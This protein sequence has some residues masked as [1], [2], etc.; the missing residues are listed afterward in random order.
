[1]YTI[2]DFLNVGMTITIY[3]IYVYY[4]SLCG[5]NIFGGQTFFPELYYYCKILFIRNKYYNIMYKGL[6]YY[7]SLLPIY[8]YTAIN[9]RLYFNTL[10]Y[11]FFWY[12]GIM[13]Q[14]CYHVNIYVKS[15]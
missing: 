13:Y 1:M 8:V 14:S 15:Q 11:R 9:A 12:S 5:N 6:Y 7:F 2:E 10:L 4:E 3:S